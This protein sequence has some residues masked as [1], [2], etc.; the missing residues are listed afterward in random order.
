VSAEPGS[1]RDF[2]GRA[3]L[4][5]DDEL[6][7]L[8]ACCQALRRTRYRVDTA[9]TP[10]EALEKVRATAYD[11]AVLD[12][13]MPRMNG[14]DLLRAMRKLDPDLAVIMVTAYATIETAVEAMKEGAC[15]YLP[16]PF[17]PEE[18]R[19]A[20]RRALERQELVHENRALR[21]RLGAG[22][23][24]PAMVGSMAVNPA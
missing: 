18:L 21:E 24:A 12:L 9:S 13:K 10:L 20:V 6:D 23:E 14:I 2:A 11:A 15:D 16:K 3:I 7:A 5:V 1:G 22:P 8:D 17:T 4:L 19:L